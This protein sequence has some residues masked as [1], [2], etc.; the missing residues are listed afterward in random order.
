MAH[1]SRC[2]IL[3]CLVE[4]VKEFFELDT[5]EKLNKKRKDEIPLDSEEKT[6]I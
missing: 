2:L 4:I 3:W 6:R 1:A 5:T